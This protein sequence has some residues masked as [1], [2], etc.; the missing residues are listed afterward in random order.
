M[1]GNVNVG[2]FGEDIAAKFLS[3]SGLK[4]ICRN[5]RSRFG[6]LDIIA[7]DKDD[8]LV[9]V[10]V[11]TIRQFGNSAIADFSPEDQMSKSKL[12]KFKKIA[13][14]FANSHQELVN[15]KVGWRLDFIGII[16]DNNSSYK[17]RHYKNIIP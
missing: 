2:K 15:E 11:K 12:T 5:F 6:E 9:F 13:E 14:Y 1:A 7:K 8:T 17:I 10:E 4:V 16:L 3:S